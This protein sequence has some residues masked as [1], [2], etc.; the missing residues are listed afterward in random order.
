[1]SNFPDPRIPKFESGKTLEDQLRAKKLNDFVAYVVSQTPLA[2]DGVTIQSSNQGRV[3]SAPTRTTAYAGA[4]N[5]YSMGNAQYGSNPS[6]VD[7]GGNYTGGGGTLGQWGGVSDAGYTGGQEVIATGGR[8]T[9]GT[10]VRTARMDTYNRERVPRS[11][12]SATGS[13]CGAL[14]DGVRVKYLETLW[15]GTPS[16]NMSSTT[17]LTYLNVA[18]GGMG[19]FWGTHRREVTYDANGLLVDVSAQENTNVFDYIIP[20][21]SNRYSM[22]AFKWGANTTSGNPNPYGYYGGSRDQI[23]AGTT[24]VSGAIPDIWKQDVPILNT[25]NLVCYGVSGVPLRVSTIGVAT[26][27]A[28]V[29]LTRRMTY[30]CW[31]QLMEWGEEQVVDYFT[32]LPLN[33]YPAGVTGYI[34]AYPGTFGGNN[35]VTPGSAVPTITEGG[36]A[37]R[38]DTI[39]APKLAVTE[40][41]ILCYITVNVT[42][43][44]T[45]SNCFYVVTSSAN[46]PANT[47]GTLHVRIANLTEASGVIKVSNPQNVRGSQ[48]YEK[49]GGT[50]SGVDHLY[51]LS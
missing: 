32:P 25:N 1:M 8:I 29:L 30:N 23:T 43:A 50:C 24:G 42:T 17:G 28:P 19:M 15:S 47:T 13:P 12:I 41:I 16:P 45:V 38:I 40:G 31:G 21:S 5:P 36:V 39:P 9:A 20:R 35:E 11:A 7:T 6:A 18:T 4:T 51:Y 33:I 49:N 14:H 10:T 46:P 48:T 2:G 37:V 34:S 3:I 22:G 27:D 44:G 26:G